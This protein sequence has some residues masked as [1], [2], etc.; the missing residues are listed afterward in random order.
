MSTKRTPAP[1]LRDGTT[2]YALDETGKCNRFF[3]PVHPGFC[4]MAVIAHRTMS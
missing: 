1:W 4:H 2:V 3:A